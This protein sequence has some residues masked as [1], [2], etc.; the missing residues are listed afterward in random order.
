MQG[1][2]RLDA[3]AGWRVEPAE[4]AVRLASEG[5]EAVSRFSVTPPPNVAAG[6]YEIRA[7]VVCEGREFGEGLQAIA[8]DH[9]EER[10]V[11]RPARAVA[12]SLD[13]R[14][15]P[16][17]RIGYVM[18]TGDAVPEAV[19]QLGLEVALLDEDALAYGSLDRFSTIVLG[20]RAYRT[21]ADLRANQP[22]LIAWVERG[23][24]LVVQYQSDDFNG[25]G[26]EASPYAPYPARVGGRRVTDEDSPIVVLADAAPVLLAP[27]RIGTDDWK[28]WQQDRGTQ[29]LDARDPRYVELVSAPDRF[30]AD[31]E[32]RKGL[33]VE[34]AV[35]RGTWTYVGLTLFR[36]LPAGVPGA[37]RL[38]ANLLSRP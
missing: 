22:R 2:V 24:H 29:L 4:A 14:V 26:D 16:A 33:L 10:H 36:Q 5:E 19:A 25:P 18:G 27:N 1:T 20:V 8:Y 38:L 31:A 34:A 15:K 6:E 11:F 37:Y 12:R 3:P 32:P 21:R 17:A 28:G 30:A 9:I 7:T 35:G 23:G 13:V